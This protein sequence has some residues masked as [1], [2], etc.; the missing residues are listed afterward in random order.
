MLL[1]FGYQVDPMKVR[2]DSESGMTAAKKDGVFAR[3]KHIIIRRNYARKG[4][5]QKLVKFEHTPTAKMAA[6]FLTKV[7]GRT[8]IDE[9][10]ARVGMID[11]AK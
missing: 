5:E 9:D 8:G 10:I 2:S 3:N 11:M 6:E 1:A 7:K 4:L